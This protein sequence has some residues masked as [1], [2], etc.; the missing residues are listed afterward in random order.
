MTLTFYQF[1]YTTSRYFDQPIDLEMS[2]L[3][4]YHTVNDAGEVCVSA[5]QGSQFAKGI[6]DDFNPIHDVD[7]KRFCVPGDLL[8]SIALSH[9]GLRES[10]SCSFHELIKADTVLRYPEYQSNVALEVL[11]D[12]DKVALS[13]RCAGKGS[14]DSTK[15]EQLIRNYVVFSGQNFPHIL[16][17]LMQEHSVMINP[18]RPLVIYESMSL[19]FSNFD[20]DALNIRLTNTS[21]DVQGKRGNAELGFSICDGKNEIGRG[22]KKLVLS[23]LRPYEQTAIDQM[24]EQYLLSKPTS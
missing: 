22:L 3:A 24:C 2:F 7:S 1:R 11:N 10:I 9:Y 17:P 20:F 14:Q 6:A 13:V 8:F 12:R 4:P 21:L 18:A 16:V 23:G 15:V 19:E 5:E